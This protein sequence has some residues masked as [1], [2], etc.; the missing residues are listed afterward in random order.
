MTEGRKPTGELTWTDYREREQ[1]RPI[2]F[3]SDFRDFDGTAG[4]A[5]LIIA[6]N[7]HLSVSDL[8]RLLDVF[9][10][11]RSRSWIQRRRWMYQDPETENPTGGRANADG[12]DERAIEIM[13]DNS[14]LSARDLVRLLADNNIRRSRNWVWRNRCK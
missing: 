6:A 10:I 5:H 14:T 4:Q 1:S 12:K 3:V 11:E 7:R 8:L 2:N 13:R 9:G